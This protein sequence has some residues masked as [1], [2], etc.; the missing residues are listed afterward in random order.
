MPMTRN[1]SLDTDAQETRWASRMRLSV[2]NQPDVR[3]LPE[4]CLT[5]RSAD[6]HR[7]LGRRRQRRAFRAYLEPL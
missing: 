1:K 3:R 5:G 6:T 4:R 7:E 2:G